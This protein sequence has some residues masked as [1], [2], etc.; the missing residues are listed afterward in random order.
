MKKI[1]LYTVLSISLLPGALHSL[2]AQGPDKAAALA[3]NFENGNYELSDYNTACYF[4]LAGN[5]KLAMIYLRKA[6]QD[7][8]SQSKTIQEDSDLFSLHNEPDWPLLVQQVEQNEKGGTA[9]RNLFFNQPTFWDSKFFQS[10]YKE[11]IPDEEKTAGLSKFWSEAKYNFINFDLVPELNI[12]SLYMAYLPKVT[13]TKS[14]L[15][16]YKLLTEFC[17]LLKDAHTNINA[18]VELYNEVYARPLLRTRLIEDKVIVIWSD[19]SLQLKGIRVGMEIK[20]VNGLPVKEYA[21]KYVAPYQSCSTAQDMLTRKFDYALFS[22]SVEEPLQLQLAD[23]KGKLFTAAV[24]RVPPAERSAKMAVPDAE[25][26][27]L[28]RNI[29]YLTINTFG[30]DK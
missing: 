1:L 2:Y 12:D 29:A 14:T 25:Y 16:F 4:S 23:E 13:K 24:N 18:P 30:N 15:E 20:T 27:L 17:A 19:T 8:F 6:V 7:G 21:D 28:P 11:N 5:K 3:E 26:K 10:P 22:G 9:S